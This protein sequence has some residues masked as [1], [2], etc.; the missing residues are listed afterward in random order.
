MRLFV[1][2]SLMARGE[3]ERALGHPYTGLMESY[4]LDGFARDWSANEDGYAYLSLA[5][6]SGAH[7]RG[8]LLE[9]SEHDLGTLDKWESTYDRVQIG[10]IH[11]YVASKD[12]AYASSTVR[13]SYLLLVESALGEPLPKLP[14][15]F[16]V[17]EEA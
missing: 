3:V 5:P 14:S 17:A 10:D 12:T 8:C 2:G 15:H 16:T 11:V 6:V 7:T 4:V 9:L 13:R 1:Y